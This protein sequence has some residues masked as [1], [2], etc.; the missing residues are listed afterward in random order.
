MRPVTIHKPLSSLRS[1]RNLREY[2]DTLR[3][4]AGLPARS[5]VPEALRFLHWPK[6]KPKPA[7]KS[8]PPRRDTTEVIHAHERA[9]RANT[10]N[11]HTKAELAKAVTLVDQ[12]VDAVAGAFREELD[13]LRAELAHVKLELHQLAKRAPPGEPGSCTPP[14]PFPQPK[15]SLPRAKPVAEPRGGFPSSAVGEVAT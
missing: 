11:Q 5:P 8:P 14:P 2:F 6:T 7:T 12:V 10:M 13:E 4:Q 9:H 3:L 1:V 15:S